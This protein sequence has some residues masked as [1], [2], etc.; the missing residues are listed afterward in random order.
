MGVEPATVGITVF[1]MRR[2]TTAPQQLI[3]IAK[4]TINRNDI[5]DLIQRRLYFFIF[6]RLHGG[7]DYDCN[8]NRMGLRGT[9]DV[10]YAST[11]V[12]SRL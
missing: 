9:C 10:S 6:V 2:S 3:I 12:Q 1:T 4:N 5:F 11:A 7:H 8:G